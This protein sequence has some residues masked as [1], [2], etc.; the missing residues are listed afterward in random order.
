MKREVSVIIPTYNRADYLEEA[1]KSVLHQKLE[2]GQ[3]IEVIVVDDGSTDN[4]GQIVKKFGDKIRYYKLPHSGLPAVA[5]NFGINKAA[6][7]L[8]AF[9]D[10]DDLWTKDKLKTQLREFADEKVVL[11]YGNADIMDQNGRRTGE[12]VIDKS[13]G[14]S[15]RVFMDLVEVNFVSTLTV[16]ALRSSI[17][18]AGG[19]NESPK[20]K[21]VE[22]Y[23]LWLRLARVGNFAFVNKVLAFHRRH[24]A[25]VSH[26]ISYGLNEHI[27]A[28]YDSLLKQ[29]LSEQE[30]K[31]VHK[32]KAYILETNAPQLS[33]LKRLVNRLKIAYEKSRA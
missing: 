17:V 27:I 18:K 11:S 22:D 26:T 15:G 19:F 6:Y 1:I 4:T 3:K 24:D 21:A 33:R 2:Q 5:R 13:A 7:E 20:L 25:N 10:S 23:E 29:P 16:A 32:K 12:T 30:Q 9:Q 31:A 28:V 14:K 8:I